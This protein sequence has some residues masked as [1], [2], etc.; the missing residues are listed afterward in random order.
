M[1]KKRKEENGGKGL[2]QTK[3]LLG[4][5]SCTA[6]G[7]KLNSV[8]SVSLGN[9]APVQLFRNK[10]CSVQ[11]VM[12]ASTSPAGWA[13]EPDGRP[14]ATA[15]LHREQGRDTSTTPATEPCH[16]AASPP[17]YLTRAAFPPG[18]RRPHSPLGK[19]RGRSPDSSASGR[20]GPFS[21]WTFLPP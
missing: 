7:W 10:N 5:Y 14:A 21:R 16:Q 13:R 18:F 6:Q 8:S 19:R 12:T 20:A 11:R 4:K 17:P 15:R 1:F 9:Q 3:N 2:K